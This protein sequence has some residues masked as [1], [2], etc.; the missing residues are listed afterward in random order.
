M[1]IM[2]CSRGYHLFLPK[3][4]EG[5]DI[6]HKTMLPVVKGKVRGFLNKPGW[7]LEKV[8]KG[9]SPRNCAFKGEKELKE[10]H[11]KNS[12][13]PIPGESQ[14]EAFLGSANLPRSTEVDKEVLE[15]L[16]TIS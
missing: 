12:A 3:E 4:E 13:T 15:K 9:R 2:G 5:R 1:H 8:K 6:L 16:S 10:L 7:P 11:R 14:T